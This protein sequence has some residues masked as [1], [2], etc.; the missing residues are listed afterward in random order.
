MKPVLLESNSPHFLLPAWSFLWRCHLC[1]PG[2]SPE[3]IRHSRPFLTLKKAFDTIEKAVL[4]QCLYNKGICDRTWRIIKSW[5]TSAIN[6]SNRGAW[7]AESCNW[8]T[9][10][11]SLSISFLTMRNRVGDRKD[12]CRTTLSCWNSS[13]T[14]FSL[15]TSDPRQRLYQPLKVKLPP[16][17]TS[18]ATM[19]SQASKRPPWWLKWRLQTFTVPDEASANLNSDPQLLNLLP[20]YLNWPAQA[21]E[22]FHSG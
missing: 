18:P 1:N 15:M 22:D 21:S 19:V 2:S 8:N 11:I 5:C 13:D 4:L 12:P 16:W 6:G 14:V 9:C 17:L 20:H 10:S 7:P 3:G